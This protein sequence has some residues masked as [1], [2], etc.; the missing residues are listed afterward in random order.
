VEIRTGLVHF[1]RQEH[2]AGMR[3][4]YI[5]LHARTD[6]RAFMEAQFARLGIEAERIAATTPADIQPEDLARYCDA[7]EAAWLA[8]AELAGSLSHRRAWRALLDRD[9]PCA[10]IVEDDVY[11]SSYLPAFLEDIEPDCDGLDIIRIETR[12]RRIN[13]SASMAE[14]KEGVTL[15]RPFSFE[16]GAAGYIISRTGARKLLA[17]ERFFDLPVDDSIF[18][19][20]STLFADLAIRQTVP[21]LCTPGDALANSDESDLWKSNIHLDRSSRFQ[22]SGAPLKGHRKIAREMRRLWLQA[23]NLAADALNYL[24][25]GARWTIIPFRA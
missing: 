2:F 24:R 6:R 3:T 19:P 11:L 22:T 1:G 17:A 23:G 4:Y 13:L 9:L 8:P 15:H 18:H 25:F 16:W 14:R 10:L 12:K 5:N 21:G 20:A 7:T